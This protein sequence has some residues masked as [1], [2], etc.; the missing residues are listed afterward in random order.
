MMETLDRDLVQKLRSPF[1]LRGHRD[2]AHT[3]ERVEAD[4]MVVRAICS[5][6]RWFRSPTYD[7]FHLSFRTG[8]LLLEEV[9]HI[10]TLYAAGYREKSVELLMTEFSITMAKKLTTPT[11]IPVRMEIDS[12][13]EEQRH[14]LLSYKFDV[15]EGSWRGTITTCIPRRGLQ[16]E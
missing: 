5:V 2:E 13:R 12:R 11:G 3:I 6:E 4:G 10:H 14:L 7:G 16:T 15:G 1:H 9:A 8:T